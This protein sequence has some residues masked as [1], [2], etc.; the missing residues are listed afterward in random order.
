LI[1]VLNK[2]V[3]VL[4]GIL[5]AMLFLTVGITIFLTILAKGFIQS[6]KERKK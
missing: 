1:K 4:V 3:E 2:I 5:G 6:V